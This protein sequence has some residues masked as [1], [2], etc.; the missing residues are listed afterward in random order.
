MTVTRKPTNFVVKASTPELR[1][2]HVDRKSL[3]APVWKPLRN[4]A[5]ST[6]TAHQNAT[7]R[8]PVTVDGVTFFCADP[9][10]PEGDEH[11]VYC[12]P[13]RRAATR[14]VNT[15]RKAK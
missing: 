11:T 2:A 1:E 10:D 4:S 13:H 14:R 12:A 15:E 6:V 7:C 8:W 9:L 3:N 5:P